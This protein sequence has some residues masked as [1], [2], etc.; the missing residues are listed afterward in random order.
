MN[1]SVKLAA[2]CSAALV[3]AAC[4]TQLQQ[5]EKSSPQGSQ[6]DNRL[7]TEYVDLSK[8]E[9]SQGDYTDSDKYARRAMASGGGTAPQPEEIAMRR[10]PGD[11]V[12]ELTQ[13]RDRLNSALSNPKSRSGYPNESAKAQAM[14]DCWM[15]QQEENFQPT[16]IERCRGGFAS[17][18]AALEDGLKPAPV[19]AKPAPAP[20]AVQFVVY[21]DLDK[22]ELRPDAAA[23]VKEAEAA[24]K[25]LGGKVTVA[26]Y[27]DTTGSDTYNQT[28]SELRAG[29]VAKAMA[30]GGVSSATITTAGFGEKDLAVPSA[31]NKAEARNRRAVIIVSPQ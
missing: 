16:H 26:G 24:A 28:L 2:A 17:A 22:S 1:V 3:L 12:G 4:G 7:Y 31:D 15:E 29:A 8:W 25:K 19:A 13:A 14:F 9:Y 23:V 18:I 27:T 21:F 30:E 10:L 6:F 20:E 11:K 5:A